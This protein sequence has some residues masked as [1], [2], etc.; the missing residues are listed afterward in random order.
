MQENEG[1]QSVQHKGYGNKF[2]LAIKN[3]SQAIVSHTP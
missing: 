1:L 2:L 3:S